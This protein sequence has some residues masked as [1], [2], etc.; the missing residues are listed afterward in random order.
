MVIF[1]TNSDSRDFYLKVFTTTITTQAI[2]IIIII[3]IITTTH[4]FS[5]LPPTNQSINRKL[6]YSRWYQLMNHRG[7]L[8]M[9]FVLCVN[10]PTINTRTYIH[11][12]THIYT[13]TYTHT[14]THTHTHTHTHIYIYIYIYIY[15]W[16]WNAVYDT[17][18]MKC[19][20]TI[21]P[22]RM[23]YHPVKWRH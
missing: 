8:I 2:K 4:T 6:C 7:I 16:R 1:I 18:T 11:T 22:D 10:P 23:I 9:T 12:H 21:S 5:H 20:Y 14:Y 13:N 17:T 3:I 19:E 15:L